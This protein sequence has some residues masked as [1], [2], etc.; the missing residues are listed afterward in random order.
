MENYSIE[1][2]PLL[3]RDLDLLHNPHAYPAVVLEGMADAIHRHLTERFQRMAAYFSMSPLEKEDTEL[4]EADINNVNDIRLGGHWSESWKMTD[5][6]AEI[7]RKFHRFLK[8]V[9]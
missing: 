7:A 1:Q 6:D 5:E 9:R 8:P 4:V 2:M 3:Y